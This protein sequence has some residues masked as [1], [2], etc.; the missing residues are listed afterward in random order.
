MIFLKIRSK[1]LARSRDLAYLYFLTRKKKMIYDYTT[2]PPRTF[3]DECEGRIAD[4]R[5]VNSLKNGIPVFSESDENGHA[6][7]IF[8][9]E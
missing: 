9:R 8:N 2:N 7:P 3:V 6:V 1:A 5:V 4:V